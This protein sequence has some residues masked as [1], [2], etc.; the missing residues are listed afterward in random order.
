MSG[1]AGHIY[2]MI[3]RLK[4][5]A[6]LLKKSGYFKTKEELLK[7]SGKTVY[8]YKQATPEQL[9]EIRKQLILSRKKRFITSIVSLCSAFIVATAI[10]LLLINWFI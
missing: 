6:S 2:D 7:I 8:E 1:G 5:N 3:G 10:I 4:G 9:H